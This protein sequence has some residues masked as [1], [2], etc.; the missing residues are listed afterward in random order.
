MSIIRTSAF[1]DMPSP[2]SKYTVVHI[3]VFDLKAVRKGITIYFVASI[4]SMSTSIIMSYC[5]PYAIRTSLRE[6]TS[7]IGLRLP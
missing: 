4:F 2:I 1:P 5:C 3:C 6:A 7:I